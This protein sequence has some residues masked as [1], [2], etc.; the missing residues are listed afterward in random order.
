MSAEPSNVVA[1]PG[2]DPVALLQQMV[3]AATGEAE[4]VEADLPVPPIDSSPK[5]S[6]LWF[7]ALKQ[8]PLSLGEMVVLE[9]LVATQSQLDEVESAWRRD[10]AETTSLGSMNQSIVEP[11]IQEMRLLRQQ[12]A[13]LVKQLDL[14]GTGRRRP[15]RPTRSQGGGE[16]GK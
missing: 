5:A 6:A 7:A 12:I 8:R 9:A 14:D 2:V 16:W 1:L 11:R 13:A 15:G 4:I 3:A 10:G